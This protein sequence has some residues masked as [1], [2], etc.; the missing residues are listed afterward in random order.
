MGVVYLAEH[1]TTRE[2]VAVKVVHPD[3]VADTTLLQ[4][5]LSEAEAVSRIDDPH[6]VR[7]TLCGRTQEGDSFIAMELLDG[8]GLEELLRA[9]GQLAIPRALHIARQIASGLAAAH[10]HD[11]VHR[12][13]KPDNIRLVTRGGKPD[14]VKILDFG[15]AKLIGSGQTRTGALLGTP[16][17]MAPESSKGSKH[18][19]HRA[20]IYA[21]G[22]VLYRMVTGKPPFS[23]TDFAEVLA[24]HILEPPPPP[25]MLNPSISRSLEDVILRALAKRP[26]DRYESMA[27]FSAAL[28]EPGV[29][30]VVPRALPSPP[31]P[32]DPSRS[33]VTVAES[34]SPPPAPLGE[35]PLFGLAPADHRRSGATTRLEDPSGVPPSRRGRKL[36]VGALVAGTLALGVALV[37][38]AVALVKVQI[39]TTPSGAAVWLDGVQRGATPVTLRPPRG[40]GPLALVLE[41]PGYLT[42]RDVVIP[43]SDQTIR[44]VLV[45]EEAASQV[46]AGQ[47]PPAEPEPESTPTLEA[48]PAPRKAEIAPLGAMSKAPPSKAPPPKEPPRRKVARDRPRGKAEESEGLLIKPS[49]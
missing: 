11:I 29:A 35:K 14:F 42:V 9:E 2:R 21:L 15:I 25:A 7:V 49:F 31:L 17:Y 8:Q 12:D 26:D 10:R 23:G 48:P 44:F 40:G 39:L 34:P 6:I 22:C 28:A 30:E 46:G 43:S 24:Q 47:P 33:A 37:A 20:D 38:T 19:D 1:E 4:R 5:F 27:A 45:Q 41:R 18:V 36:L 16:G 13:L 3:R 32:G